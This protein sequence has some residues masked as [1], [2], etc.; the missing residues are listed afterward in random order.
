MKIIK[1]AVSYVFVALFVMLGFAMPLINRPLD[2]SHASDEE[3]TKYEL[4]DSNYY[5]NLDKYGLTAENISVL[6]PFDFENGSRMDG[7]A[8][9]F[10]GDE[11]NQILD[12]NITVQGEGSIDEQTKLSLFVWIYFDSIYLHNL[13]ITLTLQN[14]A[15]LTWKL[16]SEELRVLLKKYSGIELAQLPFGYNLLELPFEL[17]QVNGNYSDGGKYS[18][19]T[20]IN[21]EFKSNNVL[22]PSDELLKQPYSSNFAMLKFYDFYLKEATDTSNYSVTKQDFRF[23]AFNYFDKQVAESVCVNDSLKLPSKADAI[24][25]AW[26]GDKNLKDVSFKDIVW[27]VVI[28]SPSGNFDYET[29]FNEQV[30]FTEEGEYTIFYQC[31][32]TS[33]STSS[34]VISGNQTITV[35]K[36]NPIYFDKSSIKIEPNKTY[37]INVHASSMI[38]VLS[39]FSFTSSSENL[40]INY[41]GN[42][43]FEITAKEAGEYVVTASVDANRVVDPSNK[44]YSGTLKIEVKKS[45]DENKVVLKWVLWFF[46]GTILLTIIFISIKSLVKSRKYDVK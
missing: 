29:T 26:Q 34:P 2:F 30:K 9:S 12:K 38:N 8:I 21:I 46:A 6:T 10:L 20:N 23:A 45:K 44:S 7:R 31:L 3:V 39:D 19:V 24:K 17:A 13:T 18:P 35:N 15:R 37:T 33:L 5:Q 41:L 22:P 1:R 11:R 27:R 4:I 36:L 40:I 16:T 25:Y 14:N 32:D 42:G 43:V 28:K